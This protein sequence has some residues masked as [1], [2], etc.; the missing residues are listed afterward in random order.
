MSRSTRTRWRLGLTTTAFLVAAASVPAPAHAE[1]VTDY[2][3]T[4][5]P[6]AKGAKIDDTMYGVFFED[7]NRAADGGLYAELVQNRSFEYSTADNRAYTPLTSWT[8]DGTAQVVNDDGRLNDRN[9]NYLSLGAGSAVTNAGYN[10]GVRVEEGKKYDFSVWARAESPATLTVTLQDADGTLAEARQVAVKGGWA[11]YRATFTATRTSSDGRLAVASSGA[12]ALDEVSLFPRDTYKGHKNGLRKDLAEKIAA[13][14]PGFVRFPGGCLVNTGSMQDYS[15]ASNW[16]RKRSYQW[17]DTI[18]PVE[19]RATNA[20]FW[21]YNQSYG[22]GYYEYFQFSEDVGA[23]PL[24]VVPAL[25]T[26]CGQNKATDDDALLQRHIQDTLDLIEFANG[27]V[28][29]EWGKKRAQ[30]GHPRPFHLTHLGVGNEENLPDEFFARFQKFRAAIE[31]KYPD[32]TVISNSGPDDTGTTFDTAW[33]LNREGHVDMV[34]EHY[35]NS[36]QWFLQNNDRYDSYD[37]GGPKV[38]LGEYASQGNAFKNALSEAAFMTGLERN[39]DIV[40][41]ASYA[42]LLANEDY[43]QWSPDMI[44]FNNHASWN[45]ANYE[46][47]KLFMNNVGDRVVP[48]T[49]TG[50]PAL[51]GPIS[52]AVGLSTWATTAAYDDVRVT[53]ADGTSLLSDDFGGDASKWTHNGRGSWSIQDGQYVQTDVAAENTMVWAG[54]TAWHDYDVKVK[55]TK[56]AGKE[57]FLVAFGVKDTGNFYWWNLGGWNNTTSAVEQAVDGG[58]STLI[59]KPGTIETGRTYDVEVKVRGRQVTLLLDGQEWGSFTDDK[60]AE[61]FRQV[62]TRDAKTGDLIVKVV[63]AQSADARTAIDLGGAKV[64]SKARVTTL[65]AAPDAVNTETATPVAP[66]SSTFSGVAGEFSYTFPANSVTFLRIR[67][68]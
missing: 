29:S 32:I 61:P 45:S 66:V 44:W 14:K 26:G 30:M 9:R 5:D 24:P 59:S 23:M 54:D 58:K 37:R 46:T 39:A 38:F 65:T 18:G 1:D 8:V 60:P 11:K 57:G 56:K 55:A 62:V 48:S 68:R 12:A 63:N 19:Q 53:A 49:A 51:T 13:L 4:V 31:A 41:L 2:A 43:V 17:K 50:T 22:L 36:P 25:V 15:E 35:Y 33:Q 28:T 16:E 52:G 64:R 20:N 27:P 7:I 47:Q 34:D 67:K 3:I 40:K 10:T 21:G 42:P 6:A